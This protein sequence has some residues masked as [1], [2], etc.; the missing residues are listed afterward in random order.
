MDYN[1]IFQNIS[2]WYDQ[3]T[4]SFSDVS[5]E[6]SNAVKLKYDH[7]LHVCNNSELICKSINADIRDTNLAK[8]VALLHDVGRYEQF[9]I[10]GTFSDHL[11]INHAELAVRIISE[12][13]VLHEL[14]DV[15]SEIIRTAI[16]YHNAKAVSTTLDDSKKLFCNI[17]RDADKLDIFRIVTSH[18]KNPDNENKDTIQLGLTGETEYSPEVCESVSNG[19]IVDYSEIRYLIDFKLVQIGWVYDLNFAF[20]FKQM[21]ELGYFIKLKAEL[22]PKDDIVSAVA[23][24]EEY[25]FSNIS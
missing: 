18:Y 17:I 24:A 16:L 23:K 3:Y 2:R 15:D 8:I 4:A 7:T 14:S 9:R 22:P 12:N 13:G 19:F 20:S 21:E 11:S 25:L 10:Y 6:C 1:T 5:D